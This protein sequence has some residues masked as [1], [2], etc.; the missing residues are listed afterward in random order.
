MR[1]EENTQKEVRKKPELDLLKN[2]KKTRD[3]KNQT[4]SYMI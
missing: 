2:R 3:E 1:F 4:K